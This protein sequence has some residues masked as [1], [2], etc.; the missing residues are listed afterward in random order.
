MKKIVRN[1]HG[2]YSLVEKKTL[3]IILKEPFKIK[4]ETLPVPVKPS[5][6]PETLPVPV[7]PST[8]PETLKSTEKNII[9]KTSEEPKNNMS[10]SVA[11]TLASGISNL[12]KS[13]NINKRKQDLPS[14]RPSSSDISTNIKA[15]PILR[16][17]TEGSIEQ[18][19]KKY[20]SSSI[21]NIER[22]KNLNAYELQST[23]TFITQAY[24]PILRGYTTGSLNQKTKTYKSSSIDNI[25]RIARQNST[26]KT[27]PSLITQSYDS[28]LLSSPHNT[29]TK[30]MSKSYNEINQKQQLEKRKKIKIFKLYFEEKCK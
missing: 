30:H 28:E 19:T 5:T 26:K 23:P 22:I 25:Q 8:S 7:K 9:T 11:A 12:I 1:F 4:P 20:K 21:S 18:K 3:G 17:N 6:S 16:G 14:H 13:K 24:E 29:I 15:I 10:I 2:N 27:L